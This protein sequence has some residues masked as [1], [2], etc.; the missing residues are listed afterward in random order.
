MDMTARFIPRL[1]VVKF[2]LKCFDGVRMKS[3]SFY[4]SC[5]MWSSV[6]VLYLHSIVH[7]RDSV[8]TAFTNGVGAHPDVFL[9][10]VQ[11]RELGWA[12]VH[13][14]R[15]IWNVMRHFETL[16][17]LHKTTLRIWY[18]N[19]EH[20]NALKK[21]T[22]GPHKTTK[23]CCSLERPGV[24]CSHGIHL[25]LFF[26]NTSGEWVDNVDT[27]NCYNLFRSQTAVADW[28]PFMSHCNIGSQYF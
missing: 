8:Y 17:F 14:D 24:V 2:Y 26:T 25:T 7:G 20:C 6:W 22:V 19:K 27:G 4:P 23:V 13:L 11:I 21:T 1:N 12:S 15:K 9:Q 5:H 3:D 28:Q 18:D 10:L 16:V